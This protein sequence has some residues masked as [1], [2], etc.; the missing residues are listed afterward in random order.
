MLDDY[1]EIAYLRG[2][3]NEAMRVATLN[4]VNRGLLEVYGST[5]LKT[6][7]KSR[8]QTLAKPIER[9]LLARFRELEAAT[10]IFSDADLMGVATKESEPNLVRLGLLPD[11]DGKERR[12]MLFGAGVLLLAAVAWMKIEIALGRGRTNIEFLIYEAAGLAWLTF[13]VTHPLRTPA[14]D[15]LLSDLKTLFAGLKNRAD[16]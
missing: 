12:H 8:D 1:V 11:A 4:L 5:H 3:P 6:A 16:S 15:A 13:K 7:A 2:G 10:K 14:G 9:R